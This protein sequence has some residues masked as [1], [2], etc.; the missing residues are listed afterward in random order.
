MHWR[1]LNTSVT[2]STKVTF[3]TR[4]V[5][6]TRPGLFSADTSWQTA[7]LHHYRLRGFTTLHAQQAI[8][9]RFADGNNKPTWPLMPTSS[10]QQHRKWRYDQSLYGL[11]S[12]IWFIGATGGVYYLVH[13]EKVEVTGRWRFMDT[14]IE[15][16]IA[17]GEQVY[18]QTLSQFRSKLL[19]PNHPTSR[20]ITGVAQKIIQAS[21]RP[22]THR[23]DHS[24]HE[25]GDWA[26]T[27][28]SPISS[29]PG[30]V[31]DWKI[32]VIDEPKIQ[33]AFVIP[34]GK[35]FVFTG[36]LPICKTEAG[37][38]T[39]LGHEVAHQVLRHP[40]ERMSSMKVIFLLT[41][42]L[43]IVGLD[44]AI[45]R[46]AVTLLMTLPNS[47][48][49]EVEADQIGLNIMASACYDPKEAIGVWKRMD[50]HDQSSRITRT[51]T[52]FLQTHP[53]H[54]TRI[55]KITSWLPEAQ[56]HFDRKSGFTNKAF[57]QF[58]HWNS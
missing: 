49:S 15:A 31:S 48:R 42:M 29:N 3:R 41:T 17:T 1:P 14:S 2:S 9:K 56:S 30:P 52:E 40:A 38:A 25:F 13:L 12:W 23:L 44:P 35:I 27:P 36:I 24:S 34:G 50:Q 46:A 7:C 43:S 11:P 6:G 21:E 54:D 20:F 47:R 28:G 18:M 10:H 22:P 51:A 8:Y 45:C 5:N 39:V 53:T 32:H 26:A 57:H 58:N 4:S 16:E 55:E 37:L 19:P 33:N